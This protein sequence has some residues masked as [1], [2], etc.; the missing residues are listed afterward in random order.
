MI[1]LKGDRLA[2][3]RD[4]LP[5]VKTRLEEELLP[6]Y[7]LGQR[8]FGEKGGPRPVVTITDVI[9]TDAR[10]GPVLFFV[11]VAGPRPQ[12]YFLP[13]GI[14]CSLGSPDTPYICE[15]RLSS[16]QGYLVDAFEDKAILLQLIRN[17]ETAVDNG[18]LAELGLKFTRT[19]GFPK[20]VSTYDIRRIGSEQSNSSILFGNSLLKAFRKLESGIHP[21]LELAQFLSNAANFRNS[22][23]L[24]GSLERTYPR[25]T[26]LCI[27]QQ[28][29]ENDGN[30]WDVFCDRLRASADPSEDGET[31][32]VALATLLGERTARLHNAL[33]SGTTA[34]FSAEPISREDVSIWVEDVCN[35]ATSSL[36]T[37]QGHRSPLCE[38]LVARRDELFETIRNLP[39]R[40]IESCKSRLHGDLHL[41][42]ILVTKNDVFII[43]FE[44]EPLRTFKERRSKYP[45][46][47]D[48]AG[49]LRSFDYALATIQRSPPDQG[50]TIDLATAVERAKRRFLDTYRAAANGFPRS[51]PEANALLRLF[52]FEKTFYEIRYELSNRPDWIEIPVLGALALL[53][54][55]L[56]SF[57]ESSPSATRTS[58]LQQTGAQDDP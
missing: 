18:S 27:F 1:D 39:P 42:Q 57:A 40:H 12:T 50:L 49:L 25:A 41:G 55:H 11:E 23:H 33:A 58:Q 29:I 3:G 36:E 37:L 26:T 19:P 10:A 46:M 51:I 7:L 53:D 35:N 21:E 24:L 44:G 4:L 13:V 9:S 6:N 28:L 32:I 30:A 2:N 5:E 15:I 17:L 14:T 20:A 45:P 34:E 8:W 56:D 48:V 52:L 22:P 47:K 54:G 31:A 16:D 38:Q 43:D